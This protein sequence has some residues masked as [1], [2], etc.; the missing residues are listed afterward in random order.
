MG[1]LLSVHAW[2]LHSTVLPPL[3][4]PLAAE[5]MERW[6]CLPCCPSQP[7]NVSKPL[8]SCLL[9]FRR[10]DGAVGCGPGAPPPAALHRGGHVL[11]ERSAQSAV[12]AA[13]S[14]HHQPVR[15]I[16]VLWCVSYSFACAEMQRKSRPLQVEAAQHAL[17]N[18]RSPCPACPEMQHLP[19]PEMQRRGQ[20]MLA[21]AAQGAVPIGRT[22]D[23]PVRVPA[24]LQTLERLARCMA[25]RRPVRSGPLLG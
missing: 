16:L 24:D 11:R 7:S 23:F 22:P 5:V 25:A 1:P 8:I 10:G 6:S 9:P 17:F 12:A 18:S 19:A 3:S 13:G 4:L 21:E 20:S 14:A 15:S 2:L